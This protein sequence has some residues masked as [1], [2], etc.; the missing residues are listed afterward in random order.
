M[1]EKLGGGLSRGQPVNT[2]LQR[3]AW[4]KFGPLQGDQTGG[5]A[6]RPE[7]QDISR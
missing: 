5:G 3:C 6:G 4:S 2:A 1:A 7:Q